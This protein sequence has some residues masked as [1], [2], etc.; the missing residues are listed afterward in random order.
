VVDAG[1]EYKRLLT[2]LKLSEMLGFR[3]RVQEVL[4]NL[5]HE[6]PTLQ[7]IKA[8]NAVSHA[9]LK[10]LVSHKAYYIKAHGKQGGAYIRVGSSNR[11]ASLEAGDRFGAE[12]LAFVVMTNH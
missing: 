3:K 10:A 6:N 5:F 2:R 12:I 1:I 8:G 9:D 11:K 4:L 7:K